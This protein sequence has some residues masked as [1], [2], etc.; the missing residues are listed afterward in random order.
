MLQTLYFSNNHITNARSLRRLNCQN[1]KNIYLD[2]NK[3]IDF[4]RYDEI[5]I[6]SGGSIHLVNL[7]YTLDQINTTI[8]KVGT[9]KGPRARYK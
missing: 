3:I 4:I 2:N 1:L 7:Q 6:K 8:I 5:Y 9:I